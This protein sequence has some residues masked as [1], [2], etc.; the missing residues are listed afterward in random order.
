M[1]LYPGCLPGLSGGGGSTLDIE[2]FWGIDA[3]QQVVWVELSY[4]SGVLTVSYF[5]EAGGSVVPV[6]NPVLP[7]TGAT[8]G[9]DTYVELVR[10]SGNVVGVA[11]PEIPVHPNN[12]VLQ[13][14]VAGNTYT[15][16]GP[17]RSTSWRFLRETIQDAVLDVNS[18]SYVAGFGPVYSEIGTSF[19]A[20]PGGN[21]N[22]DQVFTAQADA[23]AEILIERYV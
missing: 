8:A 19:T 13:N 5:D 6:T 4:D 14:L 22:Y 21:L 12:L 20:E 10:L 3:A 11:V 15:V 1:A 7:F 23:F 16:T 9:R 2:G 17:R 18:R